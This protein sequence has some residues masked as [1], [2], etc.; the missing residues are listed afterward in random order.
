MQ[1]RREVEAE[2]D[3]AV[4]TA[5]QFLAIEPDVR[6]G[7]RPVEL[8][9]ETAAGGTRRQREGFPI[10]P[11]ARN[12]QRAGV[13]IE[14]GIEWPRDRP[15]VRQPDCAPR[16]VV[17]LRHFG[18]FRITTE[19][20]PALVEALPA[21]AGNRDR[22]SHRGSNGSSGAHENRAQSHCRRDNPFHA[23]NVARYI[24]CH[25]DDDHQSGC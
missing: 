7:H 9:R 23:S 12:R 11:G 16:R 8:D 17:E 20:S 21:F 1:Q 22:G 3:V 5:P 2:S 15:I 10:P 4:R 13:W 19:E 6:V 14:L 18:A 24:N 25:P